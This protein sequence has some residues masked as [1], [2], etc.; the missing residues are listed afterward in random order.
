MDYDV[1]AS[2]TL[3]IHHYYHQYCGQNSGSRLGDGAVVTEFFVVGAGFFQIPPD[4]V[5][6]FQ[7][8][9]IAG[10]ILS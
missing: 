7:L 10:L 8:T 4:L 1:H 6:K 2:H 5:V 3:I 9:D